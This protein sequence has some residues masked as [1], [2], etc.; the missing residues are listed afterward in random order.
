MCLGFGEGAGGLS[1]SAKCRPRQQPA[2]M[3]GDPRQS[4][5][6]PSGIHRKHPAFIVTTS[7]CAL[8]VFRLG[9]C[10]EYGERGHLEGRPTVS[11]WS[12]QGI[13]I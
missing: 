12:A 5:A 9:V 2:R 10:R 6:A 4:A 1:Q 8:Q 11:A 13:E 7:I 3:D